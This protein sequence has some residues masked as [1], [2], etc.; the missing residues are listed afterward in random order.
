MSLVL[1]K[2]AP[3]RPEGN[4]GLVPIRS[5]IGKFVYL[6]GAEI[7]ALRREVVRLAAEL[8]PGRG[9][10]NVG[11][12]PRWYRDKVAHLDALRERLRAAEETAE[13]TA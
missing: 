9:T 10:Q 11:I 6:T 2:L 5:E 13:V 3:S 12:T 1:S 7:A 8:R 4:P